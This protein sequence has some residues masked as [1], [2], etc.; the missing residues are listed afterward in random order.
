MRRSFRARQRQGAFPKF[1]PGE[2]IEKF[3]ISE[4]IGYSTVHPGTA[5][6]LSKEH[7]WYRCRC[8][9]GTFVIQTQ[10]QLI[11]KRRLHGCANCLKKVKEFIDGNQ[12]QR[13]R[14]PASPGTVH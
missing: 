13:K 8:N 9:C 3:N 5:K 1:Q 6:I 2:Q 14:D 11:D 10:Q 12:P 7:H 4:Y